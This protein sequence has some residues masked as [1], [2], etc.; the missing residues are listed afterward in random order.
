MTW[1]AIGWKI[2]WLVFY[3]EINNFLYKREIKEVPTNTLRNNI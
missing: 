1:H 3:P 2:W